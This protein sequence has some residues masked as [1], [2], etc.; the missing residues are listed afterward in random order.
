MRGPRMTL[1]S[2]LGL[3]GLL[4]LGMAGLVSSSTVWTSAAATLTLGLL[5]G[6]VLGIVL[7]GGRERAFCLGFFLFGGVYL[8]LVEWDWIGGQFGQDLTFGFRDFADGI[9]PSPKIATPSSPTGF[10]PGV[11]RLEPLASRQVRIGNFVE[12]GRMALAMLFAIVGGVVAV[13]LT[14]LS[15]QTQEPRTWPERPAITRKWMTARPRSSSVRAK[16]ENGR[17]H[18][19][20]R[21]AFVAQGYD[22]R[23]AVINRAPEHGLR[24][25]AS[26][27]GSGSRQPGSSERRVSLPRVWLTFTCGVF[28]LTDRGFHLDRSGSSPDAKSRPSS[29][30]PGISPGDRSGVESR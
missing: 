10:P 4:A 20:G 27:L 26:G 1:A 6:A 24:S 18:G 12:I 29:C 3:V 19:T 28:T 7:L 30:L 16:M 2:L 11:V 14:Q 5:L 9:I 15:T 21:R 13:M 22:L 25:L 23:L 17:C 8:V